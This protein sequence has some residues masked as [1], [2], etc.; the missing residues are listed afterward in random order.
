MDGQSL[1]KSTTDEFDI[2]SWITGAKLPE[3]AVTVYG[4]ADLIAQY[5]DLEQQL[6]STQDGG[7]SDDRMTGDP[8]ARIARRMEQVRDDMRSSAVTF[9]F[10][11]L[12]KDEVKAIRDAAPRNK[13]GDADDEFVAARWI[14]A[15]SIAP[16]LT[17]EQAESIR[18]KIGEGQYAALWDAAYSAANDKR[19]SVPFSLAAS[20]AL[21]KDS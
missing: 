21:T 8:R 6:L 17:P 4:R 9:R 18:A 12:L 1:T 3:K 5:Q 15:A 16:R 2:D 10:R 11:A 19:V 14:A 20:A 13:D 7:P